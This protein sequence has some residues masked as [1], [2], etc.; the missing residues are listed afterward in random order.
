MALRLMS[1]LPGRIVQVLRDFLP[2]ELDLIDTEEND[3]ITTPDID[4]TDYHE[5]DRLVLSRFPACTLR[6]VS[7]SPIEI[8]PDTFGQRSDAEH[9]VDVMFHASLEESGTDP[10]TLQRILMRY[11]CGAMRVLAVMK[12]GL[13]TTADPVAFA[14]VELVTWAEPATYGPE[15]EQE[16]GLVVRTATLPISIRR[17]EAR[18]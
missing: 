18:V 1:G 17:R 8:R 12:Y 11:V 9:R 2:A 7:S 3:G 13:E 14:G 5:W 6:L 4:S 10:V 16:D 15:E